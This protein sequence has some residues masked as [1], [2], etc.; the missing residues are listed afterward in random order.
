MATLPP[1]KTSCSRAAVSAKS[2]QK[3]PKPP[4][5][6]WKKGAAGWLN[7]RQEWA[8]Q[9][10]IATFARGLWGY[11]R[12]AT[13]P[14][15]RRTPQREKRQPR[16]TVCLGWT[17]P[18]RRVGEPAELGTPAGEHLFWLDLALSSAQEERVGQGVEQQEKEEDADDEDEA[19][20][21]WVFDEKIREDVWPAETPP[22]FLEDCCRHLVSARL[23]DE[24]GGDG[25]CEHRHDLELCWE[26]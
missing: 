5:K 9:P 26:E 20:F 12:G 21:T 14:T 17:S 11:T 24:C 22:E 10:S 7:K 23:C 1:P 25:I 4:P 15:A 18:G 3:P 6:A 19:L 8:Q 2:N 13:G 16:T